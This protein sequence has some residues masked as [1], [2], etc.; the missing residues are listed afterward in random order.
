[1]AA[2]LHIEQ[3]GDGVFHR[4][5]QLLHHQM[6]GAH[7]VLPADGLH[8]LSPG[9]FPGAN[10]EH[11]IFQNKPLHRN[12]SQKA[13]QSPAEGRLFHPGRQHHNLIKKGDI[14]ESA[15]KP[16]QVPAGDGGIGNDPPPS[17]GQAGLDA[18][19]EFLPGAQ[20]AGGI[21]PANSGV[22]LEM[23]QV[24]I[25]ADV[26]R[27]ILHHFQI[28]HRQPFAVLYGGQKLKFLSRFHHALGRTAAV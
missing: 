9:V 2:P 21:Q 3:H 19:G 26:V 8:R 24:G 1:M 14:P 22:A 6:A 27:Q 25:E 13:A 11:G 7:R 4:V 17:L 20:K 15:G 28:G 18:P 5:I 23:A 10:G 16:Q 12:I